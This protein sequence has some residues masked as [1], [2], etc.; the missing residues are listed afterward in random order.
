MSQGPTS[1]YFSPSA[2]TLSPQVSFFAPGTYEFR[3][4]AQ[5]GTETDFDRTHVTLEPSLPPNPPLALTA[6]GE[7]NPYGLRDFSPTFAWTFSDDDPGDL[8]S[9]FR[10][11]VFGS[12][13]TSVWDSGRV[14]SDRGSVEYA[15]PPL[16]PGTAYQW[17]VTVWDRYNLTATS[18]ELAWMTLAQ[19]SPELLTNPGFE[20]G[21]SRGWTNDVPG[22]MGVG[23]KSPAGRA[24][25][26]SG[27][28]QAFWISSSLSHYAA[29]GVDL[30]SYGTAIDQGVAWVD[31]TGWLVADDYQA[32][33]PWDQ[34][35]LQV[36]FYDRT[37]AELTANRYDTGTKNVPSWA[38]Y[39]LQSF[40]IPTGVRSVEVRFNIW[41]I[42]FDAGVADDF[43]VR[44][45]TLPSEPAVFVSAPPQTWEEIIGGG[46]RLSFSANT[47][48]R[49]ALETST[50][51][52]SWS[53][54]TEINYST[55]T[56]WFSDP[57]VTEV[58]GRFYRARRVGL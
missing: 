35:Y 56:V 21:D 49:Y 24:G 55:G 29:Q 22:A 33:P 50:N 18:T 48:G 31:A 14:I 2:A 40:R 1:V 32:A 25:P 6:N 13:A 17:R 53:R 34:F 15:G 12:G 54:V 36:R 20:T 5:E 28:Y 51:L 47:A 7:V 37:G 42:G 23:F 44:V 45:Y 52:V 16:N 43:S 4:I 9:A 30:S 8:Q 38:R 46:F 3:L 11:E 41:E 26:R 57:E 39:G 27:N 19:V 10:V 58:G